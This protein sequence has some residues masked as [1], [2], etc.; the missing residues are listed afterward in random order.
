MTPAILRAN[1]GLIPVFAVLGLIA[2]A[3]AWWLAPRRG[4][5]RRL[6][7]LF[8]LCLAGELSST[9]YPTA[10]SSTASHICSYSK[11]LLSAFGS[12]Q[13]LLN[14]ALYVPL[15]LCA[16]LLLDRPLIALTG[17][18]LLSAGTETAQAL[19][20]LGR[21]CDS[22]DFVTNATGAL[23]GVALVLGWRWAR[24]RAF[25]PPPRGELLRSGALLG[26]GGLVVLAVQSAAVSPR[27]EVGGLTS[28]ESSE[29]RALAAKDAELVYG[30]GTQVVAVQ[31]EAAVGSVPDLLIV[32]TRTAQLS[33]EWPSGQ[34]NRGTDFSSP[35]S[36]SSSVDGGGSDG[37]ARTVAD[38]FAKQWYASELAGTTVRVY[39]ADPTKTRRTVEY[40]RYRADGL[41]EP[42]RLDIQVDP[43]GK[44]A[45]FSSR[46]VADPQLVPA[47]VSRQVAVATV[48]AAHPGAVLN[49]GLVAALVGTEW[50]PCWSVTLANASDPK[51]PGTSY[52]VDA[53]T[54]AL[55]EPSPAP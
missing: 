30:P 23:L 14:V 12:H 22:Q 26:V 28:V 31:E 7:V 51:S 18:W 37:Q 17:C 41:L 24:R 55:V 48:G 32:N 19:L 38:A 13:G 46:N 10:H 35:S 3:A 20:P 43:G 9:L 16:V 4:L 47:T 2:V 1:A 5:D 50:R 15:A 8:A 25:V 44:I 39:Q 29:K 6:A 34:L 33:I 21:A 52:Q 27:W 42:M 54:D 53:V 11:D 45:Q 36:S 40:R 49:A